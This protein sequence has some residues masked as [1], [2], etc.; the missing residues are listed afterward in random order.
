MEEKNLTFSKL[1]RR[2]SITL[3]V[4]SEARRKPGQNSVL[5][6]KREHLKKLRVV[7]VRT[8]KYPF[9]SGNMEVTGDF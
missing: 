1:G 8:R 3:G 5:N 9:G 2:K 7:K 4:S 6:M